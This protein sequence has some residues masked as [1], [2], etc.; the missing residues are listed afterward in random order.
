MLNAGAAT[1]APGDQSHS[2]NLLRR[3]RVE[4]P[5]AMATSASKAAAAIKASGTDAFA[6]RTVAAK[7]QGAKFGGARNQIF[8]QVTRAAGGALEAERVDIPQAGV[9]GART[10]RGIAHRNDGFASG[11]K[12]KSPIQMLGLPSGDAGE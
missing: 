6:G 8:A 4:A 1:G 3:A 5:E 7:A 10:R 2:G 11:E 12:A 9:A